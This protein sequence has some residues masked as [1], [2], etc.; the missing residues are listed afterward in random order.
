M[1]DLLQQISLWISSLT[2]D[3]ASVSGIPSLSELT[4]GSSLAVVLGVIWY[5]AR[6]IRRVVSLL[7]MVVVLYFALRLGCGIDLLDYARSI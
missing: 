4:G 3:P 5:F 6:A 1:E 2:S 7:L